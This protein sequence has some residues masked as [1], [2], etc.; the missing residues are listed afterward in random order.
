MATKYT[1]WPKNRPNGHQIYQHHLPLQIPLKFTQNRS[2][3][4]KI[5]HLAPLVRR[6]KK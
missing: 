4:L 5:S 1:K 3:G 2:F 6:Q